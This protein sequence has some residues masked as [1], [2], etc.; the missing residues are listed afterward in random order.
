MKSSIFLLSLGCIL[1]LGGCR[2]LYEGFKSAKTEDCYRL[3]YPDQE[4][5][6]QQV[7]V[8]YEEYEKERQGE[9]RPQ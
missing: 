1:L 7:N 2:G 4:L 6:L 3:A 9:K 8:S 5:C